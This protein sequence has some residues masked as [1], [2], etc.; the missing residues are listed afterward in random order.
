MTVANPKTVSLCIFLILASALVTLTLKSNRPHQQWQPS[1]RKSSA[2]YSQ[3]VILQTHKVAYATFLAGSTSGDHR[4]T[5]EESAAIDDADDG[6]YLGARVLAYQLLH[7]KS[8]GTNNSIPFL[9]VCTRD[10]SKRKRDRLKKDG[11]TIVLV[12]KLQQDWVK[13]ADARWIDVLAKLRLFQL[14]DYSKILFIDAD[15]LVTAPLDGVFFD[16]STLTQGTKDIP[17]ATKD[18]EA[19]MPRTYMF[20]THSDYWG[21]DHPYPPP[22]DLSYLNCGFFIFTPSLQLFDYYMSLLGLPGRFDPGFPEQNL[23][24]YA[25]R[26]DGNMPWK[27]LWYGW[28]VNW[29]TAKDWRGGARSF[30]A[31]YWDGDPSHDPV[32]KAIWKEQRAEMQGFYRGR[33]GSDR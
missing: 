33:D 22:T 17:G 6:Y 2:A 25:H 13:A 8:A 7:S 18:D 11:A 26:Q 5:D 28:N 9:V 10:V 19:E 4:A 29:P 24:N 27:P 30:H 21:Y 3:Q 31:K 32:L 15:T 16:E 12:E 1:Q 14:V 20:A 23:L